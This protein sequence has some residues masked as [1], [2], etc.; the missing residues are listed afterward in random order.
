MPQITSDLE[1]NINKKNHQRDKQ[2]VILYRTNGRINESEDEGDL[3]Q[4]ELRCNKIIDRLTELMEE[5]KI[6]KGETGR[7]VR[8]WKKETKAVYSDLVKEKTKLTAS[9]N[10]KQKEIEDRKELE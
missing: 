4:V 9:V 1:K 2:I 6:D 10:K 3:K 5:F 8:Q 7:V